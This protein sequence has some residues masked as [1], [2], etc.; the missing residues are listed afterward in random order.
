MRSWQSHLL[1]S[2]I[3]LLGLVS[4]ASAAHKGQWQQVEQLPKASNNK[5]KNIVFILSDDQ[6][7]V[8]NSTAYMPRLQKHLAEQGTQFVNHFTTTAICC[9]SRVSLWTGKHPHNT[10]VTD[11]APPFGG[12]PKFISEGH[13]DAYLPVWLQEA[14]YATFYTGKMFNAHDVYNYNSPYLAG[15]TDNNFLLDP[16]TYAYLN[17]IYQKGHEPPV[18]HYDQHTTEL[19]QTH[20]TELLEEALA[21]DRPFFLG[22]AP[23]A[24]H[25]NI[26]VNPAPGTPMTEPVPLPRHQ[27]L[28]DD[29][30]VP[31]SA[32]FNPHEASGVSYIAQ[33]P[34]LSDTTVKYL[35]HFY[36][37]R[38]RALQ[39]VDELVEQ[40]VQQLEKAGVLDDT[41]IIYSSDN[42]Y[43]VGQHRLP[44]GKETGFEEDIRVPL[45]IRGPGI[46]KGRVKESVTTHID[47]V[48][49]IFDMAGIELREEFDG[50]PIPYAG[51]ET[52]SVVRKEH[53]G[54]EYWGMALA[55]G[56]VGGFDG[57]GQYVLLNN[58]YKAIRVKAL[59]YDLYYSVWCNG[60]H[61]LYD[62]EVDPGQL[63]N[64]YTQSSKYLAPHLRHIFALQYHERP[65]LNSRLDK[66]ISRLDALTMVMKSC[67][68]ETCVSPWA[69]LHPQGD[70]STLDD[71]LQM[72]YDEFYEQQVKVAFERCEQGY[73]IDAEG[74]Q[75]GL[76]YR[77]GLWWSHWT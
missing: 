51:E 61:E 10:N 47:L 42:G 43:H 60:E 28:F 65:I 33:L 22:I 69:V 67:K 5:P 72:R 12:Y 39:G 1:P 73:L 16:G 54:V 18:Q 21:A 19:I 37:Q 17:P 38:L 70:V 45:Y 48:P 44:P 31:R 66:L 50:A 36:R 30:R 46:S 76:Q 2:T 53:V 62:L 3:S 74:P 56:E 24:P 49:T 64:L 23:V 71:A 40:V 57:H 34:L 77:D 41:Y 8:L 27:H 4:S 13:N 32:N 25:A 11:V 20:A 75:T 7:A 14:G 58:T 52:V 29:V 26:D 6:D 15:W 55:E 68:G 59:G 9:P 63:N 35:D